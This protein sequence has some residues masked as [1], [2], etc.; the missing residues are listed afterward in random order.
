MKSSKANTDN[1]LPGAIRSRMRQLH[2]TM[3]DIFFSPFSGGE[4]EKPKEKC[5]G[6]VER[7]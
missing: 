1:P 5:H 6:T 2:T 3:A 7:N 4:F